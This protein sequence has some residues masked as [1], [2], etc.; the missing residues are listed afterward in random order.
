MARNHHQTLVPNLELRHVFAD[1]M[2]TKTECT[3]RVSSYKTLQSVMVGEVGL[4]VVAKERTRYKGAQANHDDDGN[5][6]VTQQ[7]V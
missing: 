2:F 3:R 5:E 1:I 7:K 4:S 6:N